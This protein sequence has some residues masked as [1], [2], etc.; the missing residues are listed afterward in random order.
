M[1][2]LFCPFPNDFLWGVATAAYQIEGAV[3]EDGRGPSVWDTFSRQP[4]A[5]RLGQTGDIAVD[6]YHRYRDNV[7]MMKSLGVQAYRFSVSWSRVLPAGSKTINTQGLDFYDRLIDAV[8][9]CRYP[10]LDDA[11]SLGPAAVVRGQLWRLGVDP[12]RP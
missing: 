8:A 11:L 9:R 5:I 7:A 6:H 4:G 10:T 2:R 3:R 1:S 12:M